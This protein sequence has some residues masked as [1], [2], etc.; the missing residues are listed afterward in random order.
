MK[1][2]EGLDEGMNADVEEGFHED[3][4]MHEDVEKYLS[5]KISSTL[6]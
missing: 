2:D 3:N 1:V 6:I 5:V 4:F